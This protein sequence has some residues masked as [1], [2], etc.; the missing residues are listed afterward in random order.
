MKRHL[1]TKQRNTNGTAGGA[2]RQP[3]ASAK[4]APSAAAAV[5]NSPCPI[6]LISLP[7]LDQIQRALKVLDVRLL[8]LNTL[9]TEEDRVRQDIEH[10]LRVISENQKAL[11]SVIKVLVSLQEE[12]HSL[13]ATMHR[14]Q[15]TNFQVLPPANRKK[16]YDHTMKLDPN[17]IRK[18][19]KTSQ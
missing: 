1:S 2:R 19:S 16:S 11:V 3:G 12:V 10:V 8:H 6:Q 5:T 13:S 18:N 9:A 7:Q 4:N 14:H 17:Q 15:Q